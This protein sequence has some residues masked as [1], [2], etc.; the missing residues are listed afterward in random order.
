V[1]R[2]P[3][4]KLL[5]P[6]LL[7]PETPE[8]S[9]RLHRIME[10]WAKHCARRQCATTMLSSVVARRVRFMVYLLRHNTR[11][12]NPKLACTGKPADA[13]LQRTLLLL[14]KRS[15]VRL[16]G[17]AQRSCSPP[18]AMCSRG[19]VAVLWPTAATTT[20]CG[21]E[22]CNDLRAQCKF[23]CQRRQ[24]PHVAAPHAMSHVVTVERSL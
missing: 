11:C 23:V 18:S 20:H 1:R 21:T 2:R 14:Q 24:E 13:L 5:R 22:A 15:A 12:V 9:C 4:L 16:G 3:Q 6:L 8:R 19:V 7:L 10:A 17:A